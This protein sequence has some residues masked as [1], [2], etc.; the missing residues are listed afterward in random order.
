MGAVAS[1]ASQRGT[2]RRW[3]TTYSTTASRCGRP[4]AQANQPSLAGTGCPAA[5]V[6]I[7]MKAIPPDGSL[8][9]GGHLPPAAD[10]ERRM[11]TGKIPSSHGAAPPLLTSPDPPSALRQAALTPAASSPHPCA[12]SPHPCGRQPSAL[13]QAAVGPAAG[14]RRRLLGR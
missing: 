8:C 3:S 14:G 11:V 7:R 13:R 5:V 1:A 10:T 2:P 4:V 12:S 9:P 6:G